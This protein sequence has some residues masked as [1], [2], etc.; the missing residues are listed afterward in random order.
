MW[1]DWKEIFHYPIG[2]PE[3]EK[4]INVQKRMV[5]AMK[6]IAKESLKSDICIISHGL[7]IQSFLCHVK[8]LDLSDI[9]TLKVQDN[10]AITVLSYCFGMETFEVLEEASIDH[11][12][13]CEGGCYSEII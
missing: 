7:A 13:S 1:V 11:L 9:C 12:H 4:Y 6:R 2:I 5:N 10:T 3:Q 8:S